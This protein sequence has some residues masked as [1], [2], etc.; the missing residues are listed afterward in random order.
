[1]MA[2][3]EKKKRPSRLNQRTKGE[4]ETWHVDV[5]STPGENRIFTLHSFQPL[6]DHF[7]LIAL[8]PFRSSISK[9][10]FEIVT[11]PD[12]LRLTVGTGYR[13]VLLMFV[14]RSRG[15]RRPALVHTS[16]MNHAIN[17]VLTDPVV[18]NSGRTAVRYSSCT[19]LVRSAT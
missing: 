17:A 5:R 15:K 12:Q 11:T 3:E 2:D 7:A 16:P 19:R 14:S 6:N 4:M 8:H 13:T 1:M 18:T 10:S 9:I